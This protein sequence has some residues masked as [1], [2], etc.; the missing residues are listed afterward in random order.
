MDQSID[1]LKKAWETAIEPDVIRAATRDWYEYS[2][3]AQKVIEA[4]I[5]KRGLSEEVLLIQGEWP[6]SARKEGQFYC[7]VCKGISLNI[8]TGRCA[9]CQYPSDQ[10][11]YCIYCDT[12]WPTKSGQ[13]CPQHKTKLSRCKS[14]MSLRRFVN[15]FLDQN[16]MS[17]FMY[18]ALAVFSLIAKHLNLNYNNTVYFIA[19]LNLWLFTIVFQYLYYFLFEAIWQRTPAKFITGTKVVTSSGEKPSIGTIAIRTIIRL[20]PFDAFSFLGLKMYGWHDRWSGTYVIKVKRITKKKDDHI[21]NTE[22]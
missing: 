8:H 16:I 13:C 12:F 20:V 10:I 2:S 17:V 9:T 19:L 15:Y 6:M 14:A 7:E 22:K 11:G 3:E 1:E 21:N 5:L 18:S 4:E